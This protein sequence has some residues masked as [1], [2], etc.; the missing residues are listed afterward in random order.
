M[1]GAHRGRVLVVLAAPYAACGGGMGRIMAYV[2]GE[3]DDIPGFDFMVLETRG[4]GPGWMSCIHLALA[5]ARLCKV[6]MSRDVILHVNVAGGASVL[7]KGILLL[8]AKSMRA[9]V[10]VHLHAADLEISYQHYMGP[11]R[12]LISRVLGAA[13]RII[14]LGHA[15]QNFVVTRL[16][17]PSSHIEL[18][19]NGVPDYAVDQYAGAGPG[20]SILFVG[21]LLPRKGVMDLMRALGGLEITKVDWTVT[22]AGGGDPTRL[23]GLARTLGIQEKVVFTGWLERKNVNALLASADIFVLPSYYEALPLVLLEAASHG[24]AIVSTRVGAIGEYFTDGRDCLLIS[25]GDIDA[26]GNAI[27]R[28]IDEPALRK[29]LGQGARCLYESVFTMPGMVRSLEAVYQSCRAG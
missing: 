7:R 9:T 11:L 14:V 18:I 22:I 19:P 20:L 8:I 23:I 4:G 12:A 5:A 17:V 15:A 2:F 29:Y 21:N 28:M 1:S 16:C 24:R 10:I 13:D 27:R 26:L 6:L 3:R 25:A